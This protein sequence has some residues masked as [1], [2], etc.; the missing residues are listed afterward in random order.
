MKELFLVE[1][2]ERY[3]ESFEK[4]VYEY[5][6]HG[7]KDYYEM[8]KE[9]LSNFNQY[10]LK[11]KN[12]SKGIGVP[13]SWVPSYTYWLTDMDDQIRGVVRIR[14][15]LNN[16]FVRKYAGHIGYDISP[17]SRR[18]GYGNTL[19][20]LALEKA[21]MINLDKVLITCNEDNIASQRV[22]ENNGGVFE[23]VIFSEEKNKQL[24]RYWI[25]L[26]I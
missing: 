10:V 19:L 2:Q 22:I 4:M 1:P 18:K 9:A 12:N 24:R 17:L 5:S 26:G 11:L 7:E 14:T 23:S 8:Y 13:A 16:E 20:K 25:T 6:A 15:S 21:A 3:R